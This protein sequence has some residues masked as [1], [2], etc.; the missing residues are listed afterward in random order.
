LTTR[1]NYKKYKQ[2]E[3]KEYENKQPSMN[4]SKRKLY[5]EISEK[6]KNND[7]TLRST[8]KAV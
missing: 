6:W 8:A 2:L 5:L 7:S 4:K 1:K 3:S